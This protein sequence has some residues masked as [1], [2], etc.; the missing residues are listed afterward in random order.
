MNLSIHIK[1]RVT[2]KLE[3][4]IAL[5]KAKYGVT[6]TMPEVR[7]DLRGTT[8]GQA[9]YKTW[10][11]R[12]N[13]VLL[14]ENVDDFIERTV[15]H[16]LAHLACDKIYPEAHVRA[17][18]AGRITKREPH[19]PKWQEIMR[20]LGVAEVTRCHSYDVTNSKV[21]KSNSRQ[22]PWFCSACDHKFLLTPQK[23]EKQRAGLL[24]AFHRACKGS[25]L[26]EKNTKETTV[27]NIIKMPE[28]LRPMRMAAQAA[29]PMPTAPT[30]SSKLA[31]CKVIYA[32]NAS[33]TRA[34]VI[35]LFMEQAGCTK[36][37]AS[38]YYQTC[39]SQA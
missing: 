25:T 23:S 38:T 20:A 31:Q 24:R 21:I 1:H 4:G 28:P 39:K 16:E 2:A 34:E 32:A 15:P 12:L 27:A 35:V 19:G 5:I 6:L 33:L 22:V 9:F 26:V 30:G 14:L 18:I 37:G 17:R 8:A 13:T 3:Q 11:I 10:I 29:A 7:Y 36:A